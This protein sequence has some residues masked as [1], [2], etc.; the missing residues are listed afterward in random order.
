M[1]NFCSKTIEKVSRNISCGWNFAVVDLITA[2]AN[3]TD[4]MIRTEF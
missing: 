2:L 3:E 1:I 4:P